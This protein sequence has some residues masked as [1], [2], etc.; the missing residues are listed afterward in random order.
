MSH[1]ILSIDNLSLGFKSWAGYTEV[2][3]G[4]SLDIDPGERVALIGE[5]GS[6][7]SVTARIIF[8]V[9]CNLSKLPGFLAGWSL[10]AVIWTNCQR[11]SDTIYAAPGCR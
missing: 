2:L 1:P 7:K 6:G 5:S 4:I 3:H 9:V 10:K 8:G 11:P